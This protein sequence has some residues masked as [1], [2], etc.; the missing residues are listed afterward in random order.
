MKVQHVW[1]IFSIPGQS[2]GQRRPS[3]TVVL[4]RVLE[5]YPDGGQILKVRHFKCTR[6][7][8]NIILKDRRHNSWNMLIIC[9]WSQESQVSGDPNNQISIQNKNVSFKTNQRIFRKYGSCYC[10]KWSN[11]DFFVRDSYII[12]KIMRAI[13]FKCRKL[14][15]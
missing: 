14:Q 11:I 1:N 7:E 4:K 9:N 15:K 10:T 8:S 5:G 2:Y 6:K 12:I 13:P 3:L